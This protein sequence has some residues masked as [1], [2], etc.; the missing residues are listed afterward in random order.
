[1]TTFES[2]P[3]DVP[4]VIEYRKGSRVARSLCFVLSQRSGVVIAAGTLDGKQ[5]MGIVTIDESA[6]VRA[7]RLEE[8]AA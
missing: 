5:P 6:I 2:L 1:M 3:L 4:M 7:V 8:R